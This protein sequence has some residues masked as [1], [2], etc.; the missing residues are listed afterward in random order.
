MFYTSGVSHNSW[1]NLCHFYLMLLLY[2][3][4]Q[5]CLILWDENDLESIIK[6]FAFKSVLNVFWS[7]T[8]FKKVR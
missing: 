6:D 2:E 5:S 3:I 8:V 1:D 7:K 4:P